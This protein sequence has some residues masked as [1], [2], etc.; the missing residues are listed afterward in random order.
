MACTECITCPLSQSPLQTS[1][2][3]WLHQQTAPHAPL[4]GSHQ[5]QPSQ[6][7]QRSHWLRRHQLALLL[8]LLLLLLLVRLQLS[9]AASSCCQRC[10]LA[11]GWVLLGLLLLL[12]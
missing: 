9:V 2:P 1:S 7:Q 10:C 12:L 6:L 8:L 11:W 3:Q 4:P 5:Q